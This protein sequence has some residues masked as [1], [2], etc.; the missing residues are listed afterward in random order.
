MQKAHPADGKSI[1]LATGGM[2]GGIALRPR[3]R[4]EDMF[5]VVVH[6]MGH[7][8]GLPHNHEDKNSIMSYL[9]DEKSRIAGQP[10]EA[11]YVA[12]NLSMKKMFG[13]D[14]KPHEGAQLPASGPR[15]SD[16]EAVERMYTPKQP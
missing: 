3:F 13:I 11:D 8:L 5:S 15:M 6:E 10:D 1:L 7:V 2:S 12:C 9:H 14:Y 4:E 16:R